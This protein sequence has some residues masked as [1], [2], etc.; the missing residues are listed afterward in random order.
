MQLLKMLHNVVFDMLPDFDQ[1]DQQVIKV[2]F[3]AK[4]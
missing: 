1:L 4:D 3:G 2:K